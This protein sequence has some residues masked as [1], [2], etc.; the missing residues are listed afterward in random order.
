MT[1]LT[2]ATIAEINAELFSRAQ[3]ETLQLAQAVLTAALKTSAAGVTVASDDVDSEWLAV[4]L[5]ADVPGE[6]QLWTAIKGQ[7]I[8]L[9]GKPHATAT[10]RCSWNKFGGHIA[11]IEAALP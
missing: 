11:A 4:T 8:L 10:L 7:I 9:G 1:L 6:F 2:A 3:V 5:P